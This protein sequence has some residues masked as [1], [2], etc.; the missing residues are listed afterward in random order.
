MIQRRSDCGFI[1]IQP[2]MNADE[3][4]SEKTDLLRSTVIRVKPR[5]SAAQILAK[6][7]SLIHFNA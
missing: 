6:S 3:L 5:K 4:R 1:K 2:Q 7:K